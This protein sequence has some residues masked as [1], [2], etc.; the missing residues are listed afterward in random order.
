MQVTVGAG[1]DDR[2]VDSEGYFGYSITLFK[3]VTIDL[4]PG[5]NFNKQDIVLRSHGVSDFTD[6][7]GHDVALLLHNR[8][9][10]L[11]G[12]FGSVGLKAA[13]LLIATLWLRLTIPKFLDNIVADI[14]LVDR[15]LYTHDASKERKL[16]TLDN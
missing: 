5:N 12:R 1:G 9:M 8:N 14:A 16:G 4:V 3:V 15:I 7:Y 11:G 13:H 2:F 10:L 6:L